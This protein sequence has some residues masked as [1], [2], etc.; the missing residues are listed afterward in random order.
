MLL[1][2]SWQS[3]FI[4]EPDIACFIAKYSGHKCS[5]F[6][7]KV[8]VVLYLQVVSLAAGGNGKYTNISPPSA[9]FKTEFKSKVCTPN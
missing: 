3:V 1:E 2:L 5:I 7:S 6:F 8:L 9:F 4:I